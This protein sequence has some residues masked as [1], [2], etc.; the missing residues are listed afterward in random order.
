MNAYMKINPQNYRR[1]SI[2]LKGFD[3]SLPGAYSITVVTHQRECLFGEVVDGE[4]LVNQFGKIVER[5]WMDLPTHYP[6]VT[7]EAFVVMPNHVHGIVIINDLRG[8]SLLNGDLKVNN[9]MENGESLPDI[10]Q[11]HPY[12]MMQHGLPEIVRAFKS[13]SA[14]RINLISNT[15]GFAVWQRSFYDHIIR[16]DW[17]YRNIWEYIQINP[18]KWQE[19]D[20]Q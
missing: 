1:N 20:L 2:R 6:Q 16:D 10:N 11:T 9:S 13:F 14:R 7:L 12:K 5:T 3:Y 8:G 19:D 17:D 15:Q 4:M 18:Q